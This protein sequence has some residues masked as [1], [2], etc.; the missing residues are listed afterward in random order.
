MLRGVR[1][2]ADAPIPKRTIMV[3]NRNNMNSLDGHLGQAAVSVV[4]LPWDEPDPPPPPPPP[5]PLRVF[6]GK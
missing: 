6:N 1:A 2:L 3:T 5:P 4:L